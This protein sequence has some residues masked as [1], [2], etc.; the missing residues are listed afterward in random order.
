VL[1]YKTLD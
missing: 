1:A